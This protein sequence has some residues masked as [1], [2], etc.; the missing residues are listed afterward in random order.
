MGHSCSI[1]SGVGVRVQNGYG[2]IRRLTQAAPVA[3]PSQDDGKKKPFVKKFDNT[4]DDL[5]L[6]LSEKKKIEHPL[7]RSLF[8][9]PLARPAPDRA[10]QVSD[11]APTDAEK[12]ASSSQ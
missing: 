9:Q 11:A 2:E 5:H 3:G 10:H 7:Y 12:E 6:F 8:D 1:C 4:R